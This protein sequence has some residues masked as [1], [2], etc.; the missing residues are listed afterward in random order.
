MSGW[1]TKAT[2]G[3]WTLALPVMLSGCGN[4]DVTMPVDELNLVETAAEA[5]TFGTLL[6]AV[7]A[8]G[9]ESTLRG[10]GPFTVFAPTDPAFAAL[11]EGVLDAVLADRDLLTSVLLYHVVPGRI[12]ASD[13]SDGQIVTTAEGREFRVTLSGGARVNGVNVVATDI[14]ASNG[15]IHVVDGVLLPVDDNVDT[16]IGAGFTT[17]VAAVQAAGLESVLRGEGPFTI[18]APTDAAFGKLPAGTVESLL[19]D[20]SALAAILTYHVIPGRVFASDLA[21]GLAVTTV[22]GS[23]V[24]ITLAGGARVNDATLVATDIFTSNGV[25]HV[26]DTVLIPGD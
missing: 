5:G 19:A 17:L 6:T 25:I 16:A 13:L 10:P 21:N 8:A 3:L 7:S 2:A 12:M 4:D 23:P 22:E 15:V 14:E 20:P 18:F 11:P 1:K 9:L 26:I 24:T